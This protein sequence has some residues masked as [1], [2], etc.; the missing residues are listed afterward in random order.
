MGA[1]TSLPGGCCETGAAQCLG[2][3][4]G[5]FGV[6]KLSLEMPGW[7]VWTSDG[8]LRRGLGLP[9]CL[10]RCSTL[11]FVCT[12]FPHVAPLLCCLGQGRAGPRWGC[13]LSFCLPLT[14]CTDS[15]VWRR[16]LF[17][18]LSAASVH[19]PGLVSQEPG[20]GSWRAPTRLQLRAARRGPVPQDHVS[21]LW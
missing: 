2:G 9:C 5:T 21:S 11:L 10:Q 14:L 16:L 15:D 20:S 7:E 3:Q 13:L 12:A 8:G 19:P 18:L 6:A 4:G 17:V 1:L